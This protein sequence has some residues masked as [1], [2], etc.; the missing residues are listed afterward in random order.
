[1]RRATVFSHLLPLL[2]FAAQ[3]AAHAQMCVTGV[4]SND[5]LRMRMGPGVGYVEIGGIPSRACDVVVT[6]R[7]EG[8]WC[9]VSFDGRT[10][11]SNRRFLEAA[12]SEPKQIPFTPGPPQPA[13][14]KEAAAAA[15]PKAPEPT[16]LVASSIGTR[17]VTGVASGNTLKVYAGPGTQN[18][19][20]YGYVH[21]TCGIR[22][23]GA[24]KGNWCPV[25]YRGYK[26]WADGR[27]L[28]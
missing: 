17:C 8:D 5:T 11:W 27:N 26:G 15:L 16:P 9:P 19:L 2:L 25:E 10:G 28:Q 4:A 7:C 23:T 20:L 22:I 3:P 12:R 24:C 18:E 1:M 6:G 14:P 13:P 21:D